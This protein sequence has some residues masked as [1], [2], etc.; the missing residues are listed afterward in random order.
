RVWRAY[1]HPSSPRQRVQAKFWFL[2]AL[3]Q[4]PFVITNFLPI[5]GINVYPLGS[6]GN[7]L[8]ISIMAYA[9]AR[10]RLMDVDYVVR[11][12]VSFTLA[13]TLVLVPGG[14]AIWS[15]AQMMEWQEP[16]VVVCASVALA[17]LAVVLVPAL[18]D[19]FETRVQRAFFPQYY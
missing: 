11:K 14:M 19:A 1:R 6:L 17:L 18:Q 9:I 13:A 12:G 10:H 4:T 16:G 2:G 3:V 5:Y 7:G 8:T 15:L